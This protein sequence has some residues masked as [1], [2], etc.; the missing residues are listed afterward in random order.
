[1]KALQKVQPTLRELDISVDI[2]S[3]AAEEVEY[4]NIRPVCGQLCLMQGF[5]RLRKLKA[6]IVMLLGWSPGELPLRLA[7]VVPSGLTYLG[8]TEDMATQITY[9]WTNKLIL[10]ELEVFLSVWRN[11]TPNL[12]LVEVWLSREYGRWKVEEMVQLRMMCEQAGVSCN[13]HWHREGCC[14]SPWVMQGPQ[15]RP[16]KETLPTVEHIQNN[17]TAKFSDVVHLWSLP[18]ENNPPPARPAARNLRSTQAESPG[19]LPLEER[20]LSLPLARPAA[21]NLRSTQAASPDLVAGPAWGVPGTYRFTRQSNGEQVH[22]KM[23]I[24]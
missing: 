4:L 21:R 16:W 2:Y 10:E 7:E 23:Q 8:L 9:E 19:L 17:E 18:K 20:V 14:G 6:P 3:D 13:V 11:V 22:I 15:T 1:M 5:S 12:Q 24:E